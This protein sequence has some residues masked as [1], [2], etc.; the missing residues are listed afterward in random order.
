HLKLVNGTQRC[1]GRVQ[2][3]HGAGQWRNVCKSHMSVKEQE[4]IC[5]DCGV[6]LVGPDLIDF[7]DQSAPIGINLNCL[8][9][10]TSIMQ[11]AVKETEETCDTASLQYSKQIQL[12]NGTTP[13]SGRVEVLHEGKW[14]T[15]CDDR[16][17]LQE[18]QVVCREMKCGSALAA[19]N[20]AY[21]GQGSGLIVLDDVGCKGHEMSLKECPH[22][23]FP[24][25]CSHL[26]DAGVIC[27][28]NVN[29]VNGSQRCSGRL[30]VRHKGQWGKICRNSNWGSREESLV[31]RELHCGKPDPNA[32]RSNYGVSTAQKAYT[33]SCVGSESSIAAC[34]LQLNSGT[35]EEVAVSCTGEQLKLINGTDRCSGRVEVQHDGQWGT[36]CDDLWGIPDAMVVCREMD[37]G[38]P[39][40]AKTGAFYGQGTGT[41]WLDDLECLGNETSVMQCKHT[42]FATIRMLNGSNHCSGKTGDLPGGHWAPV[43]NQMQCGEPMVTSTSPDFGQASQVTGYTAKCN[44]GESS[45]SQCSLS[46]YA[47]TSRDHAAEAT[48]VCSGNMRLANGSNRCTGRVEVYRNGQWGTVCN[49]SWDMLSAEVVCKNLQCGK[50]QK[51]PET[52]FFGRGNM[53]CLHAWSIPRPRVNVMGEWRSNTQASGV[54]CAAKTGPCPTPSDAVTFTF[55]K[56]N[57]SHG[58]LYHCT[59]QKRF[60]SRTIDTVGDSVELKVTVKLQQPIISLPSGGAMMLLPTNKIE[61]Q[62]VGGPTA[63]SGRVEVFHEEV[64]GTVCND[65][66]IMLNAEVVCNSVQCGTAMQVKQLPFYGEGKGS[67]WMDDVRCTG[68][69]A[70]L[71]DCERR[72]FGSHNCDHGEDKAWGTVCDDGWNMLNAEVVC[73]SV[74]CGTAMQVKQ[75]AFYGE[76]KGRIWM[77]EVVCTLLGCGKAVSISGIAQFGQGT[78]P[79]WEASDLCFDNEASLFKCSVRGLNSTSCSHTQDAAV[80]CAEPLRLSNGRGRCSGRLEIFHSNS[81]GTAVAKPSLPLEIRNLEQEAAR[82]GWT[83]LFVTVRR[84]HSVNVR[85]RSLEN[86]IAVIVK[87]WVSSV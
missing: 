75:L 74:Q 3:R 36:V 21:F 82:Y 40:Y 17:G 20:L 14:G 58:G 18:A 8:G 23:G 33:T 87:M 66:W 49:D 55:P 78:G 67:I 42:L 48:V 6:P 77:D 12:M 16:W 73:N 52:G 72:D 10:E 54:P 86:I 22:A 41:I 27:S 84:R 83:M 1:A 50:A 71:A 31:C 13:C 29:L 85:I 11:C 61:T 37:C 56:A 65:G 38:S 81:W 47:M 69:E 2:V 43:F 30:E 68:K 9:N 51:I 70:S 7:G 24:N 79:I 15:A 46:G 19:K 25:D 32:V 35:C 5:R 53:V 44:G 45:I 4:V 59:Y 80:I 34:Q 64:W 26:E 63:C 57:F 39:L 28:E 62:L 60:A 76:G